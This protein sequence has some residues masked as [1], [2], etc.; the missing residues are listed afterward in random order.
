MGLKH[1][2]A[3]PRARLSSMPV[4]THMDAAALYTEHAQFVW[5]SLQRLG[6]RE[7]DLEDLLQEVFMVVHQQLPNFEGRSKATTW[8][9]GICFRVAAAH[10]RRA[11]RRREEL[12][13]EKAEQMAASD[14]PE[15]LTA[16]LQARRQLDA[17]LDTL[18]LEKRAVFVMF[19]IDG[20]SCQEIANIVDVPVGTVYSRLHSARADFQKALGRMKARQKFTEARQ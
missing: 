19:E 17:A 6:V 3:I 7:P 1:L 5:L 10:R 9:F 18:E 12:G 14:D 15:E 13:N 8:L 4:A 11:Y 16:A 20:L 2:L